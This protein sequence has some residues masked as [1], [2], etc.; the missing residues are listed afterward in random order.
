LITNPLISNRNIS[1]AQG[2]FLELVHLS[3]QQRQSAL[4]HE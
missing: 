3:L 4:L 2:H 1:V